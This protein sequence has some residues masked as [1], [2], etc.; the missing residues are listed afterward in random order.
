MEADERV[1]NEQVR[2]H[3]EKYPY[4]QYSLLASVRP[5]DTYALN[6]ESLWARFNGELPATKQNRILLAGCGSFSPYPTSLA[7][8]KAEITALDLSRKNLR[9]AKIHALLHGCT[10]IA[11]ETG[12]LLDDSKSL[13]EYGFIDSFGV[14]HHLADPLAG[15]QA[16]EKRLA[17]GGVLRLMVYSSHGRR[18]AESIRMAFRLLGIK[19]VPSVKRLIKK[20]DKDSR[21]YRYVRDSYE[22]TFD[23]GL[24]DAFLHPCARTFRIDELMATVEKTGLMPL[25]F[26]HAGALP[27]IYTEVERLRRLEKNREAVPNFIVYLGREN[28]GTCTTRGDTQLMLNPVLRNYVGPF[29]VGPSVVAPRLGFTNPVL[30]SDARR[31]LRKFRRPVFISALDEKELDRAHPF[32]RAMFL[33]SFRQRG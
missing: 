9:Q 21:F 20:A 4:P 7:N 29:R 14:I 8:P 11:Y 3:Y 27:D 17:N 13:G 12:D 32:L 23:A 28:R 24:A 33:I 18:E 10:N 31:F 22:A 25:L 19:D 1:M 26:A 5:C 30:D 15:L 16:L 2:L 6:L